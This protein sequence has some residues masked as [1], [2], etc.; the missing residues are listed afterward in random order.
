MRQALVRLK[1]EA[2]PRL[3]IGKMLFYNSAKAITMCFF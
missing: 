2:L 3:A 1:K